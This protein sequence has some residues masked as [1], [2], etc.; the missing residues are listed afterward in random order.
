VKT[1]QYLPFIGEPHERAGW[2]HTPRSWA[3]VTCGLLLG[4][5]LGVTS[6]HGGGTVTDVKLSDDAQ[7]IIIQFEG[8]VGAHKSQA[9]PS[10]SRL[11][12]D[13]NSVRADSCP[14]T[15]R[16][17]NRPVRE[18]QVDAT[19]KGSQIVV[20]FGEHEAPQYKIRRMDN[21]LVVF[22]GEYKKSAHA[23][24]EE[25]H[26]RVKHA[27]ERPLARARAMRPPRPW[28]VSAAKESRP[29]ATETPPIT[30]DFPSSSESG[31]LFV[32]QASLDDGALVVELARKSRPGTGYL[33][34]LGIDLTRLGIRMARVD[35]IGPVPRKQASQAVVAQVTPRL[36]SPRRM[37]PGPRRGED[38]LGNV[39]TVEATRTGP[40]RY[41]PEPIQPGNFVATWN[42]ILAKCGFQPSEVH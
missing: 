35:E 15:Q 26:G 32:K 5:L 28:T 6:A 7:R 37:G 40:R 31:D 18:I 25:Q 8:D 38:H 2:S 33:I 3:L 24:T 4:A 19:P 30:A 41:L 9:L 1:Y 10:S 20:D 34:R 17:P 29:A 14:Q 21:L 27:A 13:V 39:R 36:P 12:I 23:P 22:F 11:V 42:A 16:F